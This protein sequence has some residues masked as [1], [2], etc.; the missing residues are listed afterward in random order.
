MEGASPRSSEPQPEPPAA[1]GG[2]GNPQTSAAKVLNIQDRVIGVAAYL[3]AVSRLGGTYNVRTTQYD[4][5]G[6]CKTPSV[7]LP[8]LQKGTENTAV[9]PCT[10]SFKKRPKKA[11]GSLSPPVPRPSRS[12]VVGVLKELVEEDL[13]RIEKAWPGPCCFWRFGALRK[14][15]DTTTPPQHHKSTDKSTHTEQRIALWL[16]PKPA[17]SNR[18][19]R[20]MRMVSSPVLQQRSG[21]RK[22]TA[23]YQT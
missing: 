2:G 20:S 10:E 23:T 21:G 13:S 9:S 11:S 16:S 14:D 18:L 19:L 15:E 5:R 8:P 22:T 6:G 1:P 7:W 17:L 3:Q 4:H 12:L